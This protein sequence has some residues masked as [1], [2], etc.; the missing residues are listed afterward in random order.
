MHKTSKLIICLI[1]SLVYAT[2]AL[3]AEDWP[4]WRGT[5]G[6]G[7]SRETT[8]NPQA[9]LSGAKVLWTAN[10]GQGHSTISIKDG[11]LFT[12]GSRLIEKDGKNLYE[13]GIFCLNAETGA[14][15]WDYRYPSIPMAHAGPRSTPAVEGNHVYTLGS[16]GHLFCFDAG[17][18]DVIWKRDL[19]AERLSGNS[20]WGFST[21][22][23]VVEDRVIL[24]VGSAG[25]ALDKTSGKPLWK[26]GLPSWGLST[27]VLTEIGEQ[28]IALLNTEYTLY[29]VDIANGNVAWT[30]PWAYC[31]ADPVLIKDTIYLF[32]GKP[33]KKRCRALIRISDGTLVKEWKQ[34]RMN[35]AF[36][37]WIIPNSYGFGITWDKKRHHFQCFD[38]KA[39]K[40]KWEQRLDDWAAFSMANGFILLIEAK[41]DLVILR[42]SPQSYQEVSRASVFDMKRSKSLPEE[43]P[44]TCWTAPVLCHGKVYIRNTYGEIACVDMTK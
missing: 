16:K 9:L 11:L 29:A 7:I 8:W 6:D 21:S 18:G 40:V 43:Q 39:G 10:V 3:Y 31:D 22:P 2:A 5:N 33:G 34:G 15:I 17:T 28:K 19:V 32:G 1:I 24:N 12:Q 26:S 41:G 27:P 14:L 13:E 25:L 37:S 38:W 30:Y 44:L 20:K 4:C 42:A 23:V 35:V 36:Q